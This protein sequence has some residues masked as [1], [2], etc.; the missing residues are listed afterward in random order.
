MQLPSHFGWFNNFYTS[1]CYIE[2]IVVLKKKNKKKK[3]TT[4]IK[5]EEIILPF[6]V[7]N[8]HT[9]NLKSQE[10]EKFGEKKNFKKHVGE[11]RKKKQREEF[12]KKIKRS[13]S[14]EKVEI[15][16]RKEE[17]KGQEE[18]I[19]RI[20]IFDVQFAVIRQVRRTMPMIFA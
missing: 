4:W 8:F 11:S 9:E 5:M 19:S 16:G 14:E 2:F 20:R 10:R 13:P 1:R 12:K 17:P 3:Q 7:W 6:V 15:R 18:T